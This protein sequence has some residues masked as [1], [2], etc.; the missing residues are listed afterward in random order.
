MTK[1]IFS[2]FF[3]MRRGKNCEWKKWEICIKIGSLL[4]WIYFSC[5]VCP[6]FSLP[7]NLPSSFWVALA[8]KFQPRLCPKL[9]FLS[10][11]GP[12][13]QKKHHWIFLLPKYPPTTRPHHQHFFPLPRLPFTFRFFSTR[14]KTKKKSIFS[15]FLLLFFMKKNCGR[16][17]SLGVLRT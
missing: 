10:F 15:F 7:S 12:F 13:F 9:L 4:C 11:L 1:I 6:R 8:R 5:L 3:W 14:M 16:E 2:A 17:W